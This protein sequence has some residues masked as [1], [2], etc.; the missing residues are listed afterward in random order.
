MERCTWYLWLARQP[1]AHPPTSSSLVWHR[2]GRA[3]EEKRKEERDV[4]L[5]NWHSI[6]FCLIYAPVGSA[7]I[8]YCW[9]RMAL[10]KLLT[11]MLSKDT[12]ERRQFHRFSNRDSPRFS[13]P[14]SWSLLRQFH[15]TQSA[16]WSQLSSISFPPSDPATGGLSRCRLG[17]WWWHMPWPWCW[18]RGRSPWTG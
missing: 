13:L 12:A 9:A 2:Y 8:N 14:P 15:S 7:R 18:H 4:E 1:T 6:W 17:R 5:G 3:E 16:P 10:F 11:L